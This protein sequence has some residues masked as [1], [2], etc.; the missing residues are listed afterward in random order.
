MSLRAFIRRVG[1][2]RRGVSA[3]EFALIV[4][5]MMLMYFGLGELCEA[6]MAQRRCAHAISAIGDLATQSAALSSSDVSDIFSA[7]SLIMAPFST[8]PL[9]LRLTSVTMNSSNV[10]KVDWSCTQGG[11]SAYTAGTTYTGL[12]ANVLSASGDSVVVADGSYT[13]T[14]PAK[15]VL[16]NGLTFNEI[17]YLKPR[18]SA[19]VT[20]PSSC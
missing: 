1:R 2:D 18:K 10:A 12:P 9:K 15:Y 11:A 7:A 14:S 19:Q 3:V 20:G 17:F 8:T 16:P 5:V 6:M 4:P 13:W